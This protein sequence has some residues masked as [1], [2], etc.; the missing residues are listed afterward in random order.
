[1]I[2]TL[3]SLR[4]VFALTV[5]LAHFSYAGVEGHSTGVGPMYFML[6]TGFVMSRSY[7]S[8]VLDDSLHFSQYLLRRLCKFY[9]L[10]LL[11]LL[12]IVAIR[13]RTMTHADFV[14][15]IP[16]V[17]LLQSWIP[18][19]SYY[20]SG[21]SVSWYLSDLML[22]LFLFPIIYKVIGK[23]S[24]RSLL[25][26]TVILLGIYV[27]YVTFL[28]TDNLNYWLYVFPP[29]RLFDF[30]WGVVMWRIYE[31]YPQWKHQRFTTGVE[32]LMVAAVVL[33]IVTYPL[34]ERW[35]VA[36]LHWLVMVPMFWVFMQGNQM[37]GLVSRFLKT[38]VMIWLGGLTLET[39]LLHQLLFAI[40]WNN[41][42][43]LGLQI[44]YWPMM[45]LSFSFVIVVCYVVHATFVKP[46]NKKLL[47][48]LVNKSR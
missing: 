19:E 32:L 5:M 10:H 23:M 36:L 1:M 45:L 25:T 17:L 3:Q 28:Q 7:G 41:A 29:V 37:N 44:P 47:S 9:P 24:L 12:V 42:D 14:A 31:L 40:L 35:H 13:F 8:K 27:V 21:N 2:E 34:H 15:L 33:T 22:F 11:C 38:R 46:V 16:N 43:K 30:I 18:V 4:I 26:M 20:F 6:M 48:F 39:Y